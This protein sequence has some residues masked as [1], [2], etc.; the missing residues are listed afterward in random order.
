MTPRHCILCHLYG[1]VKEHLHP[2]E[3]PFVINTEYGLK[4][5][6]RHFYRADTQQPK[7]W[8]SFEGDN[9]RLFR[10]RYQHESKLRKEQQHLD[11]QL[12]REELMSDD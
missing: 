7:R 9:R 12:L 1:D 2:N 11:A 8:L 6:T 4:L 10:D 3:K 5:C